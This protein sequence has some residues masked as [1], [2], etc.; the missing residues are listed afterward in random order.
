[1]RNN[2]LLKTFVMCGIL[3]K[4]FK[5]GH[6]F[7]FFFKGEGDSLQVGGGEILH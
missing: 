3:L 2:L 4:F 5:A 6:V 7:K 1:M